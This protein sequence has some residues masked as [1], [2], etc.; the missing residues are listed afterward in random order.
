MRPCAVH[1]RVS[2]YSG[3]GFSEASW[4]CGTL[5]DPIDVAGEE[6]IFDLCQALTQTLVH[7][8]MSLR[9]QVQSQALFGWKVAI[10]HVKGW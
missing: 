7:R 1:A 8:L 9:T 6:V 2:L 4:I 5:A 10:Q 3:R